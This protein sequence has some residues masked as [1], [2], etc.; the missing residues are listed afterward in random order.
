MDFAQLSQLNDEQ[1]LELAE[2]LGR[3]EFTAQNLPS[4][5][6]SLGV[7]S[8]GQSF[9]AAQGGD[10]LFEADAEG[11]LSTWV[12]MARRAVNGTPAESDSVSV[13]AIVGST[14][15][16]GE[17]NYDGTLS[18]NEISNLRD[19]LAG[20]DSGMGPQG[21]STA[22]ADAA[23][24][25]ALEELRLA[26]QAALDYAAQEPYRA[27]QAQMNALGI[28]EGEITGVITRE[29]IMALRNATVG[30]GDAT[31]NL[32]S[33]EFALTVTPAGGNATATIA[34]IESEMFDDGGMVI[35]EGAMNAL[36]HLAEGR[37]F[38]NIVEEA[39]TTGDPELISQA[40]AISGAEVTGEW[41][42]A[43]LNSAEA[44]LRS[45]QG[46]DGF[47][48]TL[49]SAISQT[50]PDLDPGMI[51]VNGVM[52]AL[53]NG[54]MN[55]PS[56]EH[57]ETI[58]QGLSSAPVA[59]QIAEVAAWLAEDPSRRTEY[60]QMVQAQPV[61]DEIAVALTALREEVN[62]EIAIQ[63]TIETVV[64]TGIDA[65]ATVEDIPSMAI[66]TTAV[67]TAALQME[68]A[69]IEGDVEAF[70]A[71][72]QT[73][74][75]E[76]EAVVLE[77]ETTFVQNSMGAFQ[78]AGNWLAEEYPDQA[79]ILASGD[80]EAIHGLITSM[81]QME[82][83]DLFYNSNTQLA[84]IF[85]GAIPAPGWQAVVDARQDLA[86]IR[87]ELTPEETTPDATPEIA[88][89][90]PATETELY[91]SSL[92]ERGL[93]GESVM[94]TRETLD[95]ADSIAE[96]QAY[97]DEL[98]GEDA[99]RIA[100]TTTSA[101]EL[102][103]EAIALAEGPGIPING[104]EIPVAVGVSCNLLQGEFAGCAAPAEQSERDEELENS[105]AADATLQS[106]R[107][108]VL[109]APSA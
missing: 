107:D 48:D 25:A 87:E 85:T 94:L 82:L 88:P 108:A 100:G 33:R 97:L 24:D 47:P 81:D 68:A 103:A 93:M 92:Q 3:G 101:E 66:D 102:M 31:N 49:Y 9:G 30:G 14:V 67:E 86:A 4:L 15:Y 74:L 13:L 5:E 57:L 78:T 62:A 6:R 91:L 95:P 76:A 20:L 28:R 23:R 63:E 104:D 17:F 8:S 55:M 44:Y 38:S 60:G 26:E 1:R 11:P 84:G 21:I 53:E 83:R 71:A 79:A 105:P 75:V 106:R 99:D 45:P 80:P 39:I 2:F 109:A 12:D 27:L 32:D 42:T 19:I 40:Q 64:E 77:A 90:A 34:R 98:D 7:F 51:S 37:D 96:L 29:D 36:E 70:T 18:E 61:S 35:P 54:E 52:R 72:G 10:A 22:F 59:D 65:I 73:Y 16:G 41:D 58:T 43:S 69:R 50:N 56:A 46:T 89:D